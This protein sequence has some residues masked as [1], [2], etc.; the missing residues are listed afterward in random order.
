MSVLLNIN[1]LK[2]RA[3]YSTEVAEAFVNDVVMNVAV[4]GPVVG[5]A[6]AK[7]VELCECPARATGASCEVRID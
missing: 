5:A 7:S 4:D 6:R 3:T 1:S 2:L